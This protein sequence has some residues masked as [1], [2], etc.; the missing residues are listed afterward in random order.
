VIWDGTTP[1]LLKHLVDPAFPHVL[2]AARDINNAG[3]ITGNLT[4][5]TTGHIHAFTAR[6]RR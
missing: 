5:A 1:T 4:H 2:A 3:V 6:V